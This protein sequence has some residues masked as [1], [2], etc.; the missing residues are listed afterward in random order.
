M[1]DS[2]PHH[3]DVEALFAS[4]RRRVLGLALKI[5][6][7][8][9]LAEDVLQETFLCAH[10]GSKQFRG[11]SSPGTWLYRIAVREALRA[12]ARLRRFEG[13]RCEPPIAEPSRDR[14]EWVEQVR[15]VLRMLDSLP[16]EQRLALV[17]MDV[18][19]LSAEEVGSLLGV[20]PSTVYTRAFRARLKLK[21]GTIARGTEAPDGL[22]TGL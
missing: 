5:T 9:A 17:L 11:E 6:G 13:A 16:E 21:Q 1:N 22:P 2:G 7:N 14:V 4:H 8:L 15:Q 19:E 10:H 18:R 3:L 20:P 12:R